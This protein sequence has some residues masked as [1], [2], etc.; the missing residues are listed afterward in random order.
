MR[1]HCCQFCHFV[2]GCH[3]FFNEGELIF[4][5][6]TCLHFFM[7]IYYPSNFCFKELRKCLSERFFKKVKTSC[8][9]PNSRKQFYRARQK[10]KI[11]KGKIMFGHCRGHDTII[12]FFHFEGLYEQHLCLLSRNYFFR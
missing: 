2:H 8:Y 6:E 10:K 11:L 7:R 1:V 4:F 3:F 12:I 5:C 9:Q